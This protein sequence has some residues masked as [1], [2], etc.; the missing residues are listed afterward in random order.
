MADKLQ[1]VAISIAESDRF[2]EVLGKAAA[3]GFR[4]TTVLP[5]IGVATGTIAQAS[6]EAL[7]GLDG[8]SGVE[9]ETMFRSSD[10]V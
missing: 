8:V 3:L 4:V 2:E 10:R 5:K 6:L 1:H 7:R 9:P